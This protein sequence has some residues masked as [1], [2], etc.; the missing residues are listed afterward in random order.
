MSSSLRLTCNNASELILSSY[1]ALTLA[2]TTLEGIRKV[3]RLLSSLND[4]ASE[5]TVS[6]Y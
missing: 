2:S 1:F 4:P 6:V 3:L 5:R